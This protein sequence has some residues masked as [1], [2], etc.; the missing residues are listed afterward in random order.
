MRQA[1]EADR[2]GDQSACEGAWLRCSVFS[3][4]RC[5][6][7]SGSAH[8]TTLPAVKRY[9]RTSRACYG[10]SAAACRRR[11]RETKRSN[12]RVGVPFCYWLSHCDSVGC[13]ESTFQSR[14]KSR[15]EALPFSVLLFLVWLKASSLGSERHSFSPVADALLLEFSPRSTVDIHT[16]EAERIA[17]TQWR[18]TSASR[19]YGSL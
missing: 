3:F 2:A 16:L 14:L 18:S 12:D 15:L 10:F 7:Q 4:N 1:R 5:N 6:A 11:N 17:C 19:R 13:R 8:P 9:A